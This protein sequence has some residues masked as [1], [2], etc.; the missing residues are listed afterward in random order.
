M[1]KPKEFIPTDLVKKLASEGKTEREIYNQLRAQGFMPTQIERAMKEAIKGAVMGPKP[2]TLPVPKGP[3]ARPEVSGRP[4]PMKSREAAVGRPPEKIL[5]PESLKPIEL[6]EAP[7]VEDDM[8]KPAPA[9]AKPKGEITLEELV[10]KVVFENVKKID[11]RMKITEARMVRM[12]HLIQGIKNMIDE[13][14]G[15]ERSDKKNLAERLD[16][17]G[18]TLTTIQGHV[19]SLE[20]AFE[21]LSAFMKKK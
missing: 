9:A 5:V 2:I 21:G 4:M 12:E 7:E 6:P 14:G 16:S 13:T 8:F 1:I 18:D 3:A 11:D 20:K 17:F 19:N 15:I 10:E